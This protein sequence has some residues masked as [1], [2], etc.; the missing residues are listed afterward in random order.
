MKPST[1]PKVLFALIA[2][3]AAIHFSMLYGKLPPTMASHFG[4]NGAANG[5][6]PKELFFF[7]FVGVL[8]LASVLSFGIPRIIESI[9]TQ[10]INL[11]NKE[12][13]L[14]PE[15]RA[16]SRA[17]FSRQFAWFGCALLL[18]LVFTFELAIQANFQPRPVMDSSTFFYGLIVFLVFAFLLPVRLITRFSRPPEP[19]DSH[20]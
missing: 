14:A 5:W 19:G 11:P 8:V 2:A 20:R 9:P 16:E 12:Y 15:R 18:F 7:I 10:L 4:A 1:L 13:W 3:A 6:Q 17:F